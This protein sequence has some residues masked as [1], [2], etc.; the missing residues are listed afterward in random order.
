MN[1][2][3]KYPALRWV[4]GVGRNPWVCGATRA[5]VVTGFGV[6]AAGYYVDGD[7]AAT[8]LTKAAGGIAGAT[9]GAKINQVADSEGGIF[10]WRPH[11]WTRSWFDND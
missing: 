11:D 6:S 10:G 7:D 1:V 4:G 5:F 2:L 9:I 3:K 8:S